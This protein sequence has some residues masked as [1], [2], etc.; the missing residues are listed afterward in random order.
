MDPNPLIGGKYRLEKL[1]GAGGMGQVWVARNEVTE[2]EFAIKLLL[3]QAAANPQVVARFIQEAKVSGR[4]RHPG[5]LEIYD[6]GTAPELQNAPFLVMELLHGVLLEDAI[7]SLRGLPVRFT[8]LV[9]IAVARA[10]QVAHARGV[11]HR[12]LKPANVFLHRNEA[13]GVVPK[14]LD[15]GISKLARGDD[16][17]LGLTQTGALLGSPRF[18]S[19]EQVGS[20][21]DIDGRSD[22]HALGVLVWW[23]LVARSP[24]VGPGLHNLLLEILSDDRPRL[25]DALLD[26]PPG[27]SD[28]VSKAFARRR[29][30][31]HA[32]A[33]EA[34][35]ALEAELA[36]LGPGP[37]L[38]SPT[39]HEELLSRVQPAPPPAT[40]PL[41]LLPPLV[42]ETTTHGAVSVSVERAD[43]GASPVDLASLSTKS[44]SPAHTNPPP[45]PRSTSG[46]LVALGL[47]GLLC[48]GV[49]VVGVLMF[50]KPQPSHRATADVP[51]AATT[52]AS[53]ANSPDVLRLSATQAP[54]ALPS[55]EVD[56][57]ATQISPATSSSPPR[58]QP[59]APQSSRRVAPAAAVPRKSSDPFGGV[60]GTGL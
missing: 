36:K 13:G 1:I 23:C 54:G 38:E 59:S 49:A 48:A 4:L 57:G 34:L 21:K 10:L 35:A 22:V 3:P 55:L 33:G 31:R 45:S 25:T 42:K 15:F 2:R 24:F 6:V 29:E 9:A 30:D 60:T 41:S 47:G 58:A 26:V 11:I 39:W 44:T 46:R 16:E 56:G 32:N 27:V 43:D 51:P 20:Q 8:L 18:M 5:I 19:P 37:T 50:G 40:P 7:R 17:A 53:G 12:D 28:F 52:L 14:L